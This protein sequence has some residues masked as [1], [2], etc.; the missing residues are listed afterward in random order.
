MF[1]LK[2]PTVWL[3]SAFSIPVSQIQ[4][5]MKIYLGLNVGIKM[6]M[7]RPGGGPRGHI[8]VTFTL[9]RMKSRTEQWF[10][11]MRLYGILHNFR[12]PWLCRPP[13]TYTHTH[14]MGYIITEFCRN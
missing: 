10:V 3:Y 7:Y 13:H 12:L 5:L 9:P 2:I 11:H 6:V 4:Y 1:G 14:D 8:S